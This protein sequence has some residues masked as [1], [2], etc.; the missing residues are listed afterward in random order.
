M[1][2][3]SYQLLAIF[4]VFPPIFCIFVELWEECLDLVWNIPI[5]II[6]RTVYGAPILSTN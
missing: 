3:V 1:H 4:E 2:S 5:E 6:K